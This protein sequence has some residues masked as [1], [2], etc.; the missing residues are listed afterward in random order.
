[1]VA[2]VQGFLVLHKLDRLDVNQVS[3]SRSSSKGLLSKQTV[4][5]HRRRKNWEQRSIVVKEKEVRRKVSTLQRVFRC[6]L[7]NIASVMLV[8]CLTYLMDLLKYSLLSAFIK[9]FGSLLLLPIILTVRL[10]SILWFA[11]IAGAALKYRGMSG[12]KIPDFSRAASDFIHA[13][14]VELVFLAQAMIIAGL[15]VPVLSAFFGFIYMALLH[16]LYSFDYIW[17]YGAHSLN[18]RLAMV[19]RRWPYHLGFGTLL[20]LSTSLSSNFVINGCVFGA[21][22]P[23]FIVSSFLVDSAAMEAR[24]TGEEEVP[25]IHFYYVAQTLTNK[26]SVA[27]FGRIC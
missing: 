3:E 1:L 25:P 23:F 16:S 21:L 20:T 8:L 12:S 7:A 2:S 26:I 17:M 4:L 9:Y 11:D 27:V 13:I 24:A 5:E 6:V 19:E 14:F 10:L 18:T 22:F 15:E